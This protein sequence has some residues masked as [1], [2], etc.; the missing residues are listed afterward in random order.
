MLR[1]TV[2]QN[3]SCFLRSNPNNLPAIVHRLFVLI[4]GGAT[5]VVVGQC[6]LDN[7]VKTEQDNGQSARPSARHL[8]P[9]HRLQQLI[10]TQQVFLTVRPRNDVML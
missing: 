5:V 2:G 4:V 7:D 1:V 8:S 3:G 10:N 6:E 9:R